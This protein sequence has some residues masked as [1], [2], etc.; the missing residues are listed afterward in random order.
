MSMYERYWEHRQGETLAD[1]PVKWPKLSR[2]I[3]REPG[4]VILDFGCGNGEVL[5]RM[6]E[7]NPD[8]QYLGLDV[9]ATALEA[10]GRALE[11]A[12]LHQVEDGGPFPL[13]DGAVD[14]IIASEVIEHVYDTD[15]AFRELAR[16]LRPEGRLLVTTPYHG[17]LKN[18][19]IL[20]RGFD[21]HFDPAG[22][23]IRFFTNRSLFAALDDVGLRVLTHGYYG[24]FYP[25]P[26]SIYVLAEKAAPEF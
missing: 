15:N 23:H 11:G 7:L 8:A 10:A 22:P 4:V 24:R 19:L 5:R 14:F 18:V 12:A 9:S 6:R 20:L 17:L 2:F 25:V 1:L 13:A 26:H 16:V 21:R 3:P